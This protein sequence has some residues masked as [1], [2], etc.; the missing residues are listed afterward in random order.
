[1]ILSKPSGR[2]YNDHW[3]KY[4]FIPLVAVF[5]SNIGLELYELQSVYT[6]FNSLWAIAISY[7][8]WFIF[9]YV[10]FSFDHIQ[11]F[12]TR[13][14]YQLS[15]NLLIISLFLTLMDFVYV[16]LFWQTN[17]PENSDFLQIEL[18]VSWIWIM[19]LQLLYSTIIVKNEKPPKELIQAEVK[20]PA[21]RGNQSFQLLQ[22]EIAY[23]FLQ[24]RIAFLIAKDGGQYMVNASLD[25]LEKE[26]ASSFFR[27]NR[28][29]IISRDAVK[30]Y[31]TLPSR[32]ILLS[33]S[34]DLLS[35]QKISK[36]KITAFKKW[37]SC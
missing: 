28:Q 5:S 34:P 14:L 1:M 16:S 24:D 7:G 21:F 27:A 10:L 18:P 6:L 11:I 31:Q 15:T 29:L 33:L 17:W 2:V 26:L 20:I 32:K 12:K 36:L 35:N 30:S 23:I 3:I 4:Y 13:F 25:Q 8:A 9:K 22:S 19:V 37:L